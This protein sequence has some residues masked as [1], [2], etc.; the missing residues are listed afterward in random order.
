MLAFVLGSLAIALSLCSTGSAAEIQLYSWEPDLEG[1]SAGDVTLT[2]DSVLGVTNGSQAMH[3]NGLTSGF[4]NDVGF[5]GNIVSGPVFDALNLVGSA[6]EGGATDVTL[7]FDLAVDRTG[8]TV[9]QFVQIGMFMNSTSDGFVQY[10]T[11]NFIGGN[12]TTSF[13]NIGGQAATDGA[14]IANT[15]TDQYHV[16]IPLGPTL[17]VSTGTF[18]QIG[19]KSNGGWTGTLDLGID[20]MTVSGSTIPE[21]STIALFGLAAACMVV[22]RSVQ[23]NS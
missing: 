13:P 11:G 18:F 7:E 21:P 16:T 23:K 15:G 20:N 3:L 2:A 1:W 5:S 19:F 10:G 6:L 8:V 17:K 9:N 14:T 4:K 22:R 12:A